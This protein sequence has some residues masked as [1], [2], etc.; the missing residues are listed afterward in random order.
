MDQH[1]IHERFAST[2]VFK[3]YKS[4]LDARSP[5]QPEN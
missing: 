4:V 3:R 1:K 2:E 5:V